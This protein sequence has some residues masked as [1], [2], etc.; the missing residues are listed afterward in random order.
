M[1]DLNTFFKKSSE[2]RKV[3]EIFMKKKLPYTSYTNFCLKPRIKYIIQ[4]VR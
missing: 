4:N 1:K 2:N 3:L